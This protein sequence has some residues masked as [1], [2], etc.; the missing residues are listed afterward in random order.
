M[1][2]QPISSADLRTAAIHLSPLTYA[3][4]MPALIPREQLRTQE[5]PPATT[6]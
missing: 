4:D 6:R 3:Q 2:E 1:G 5:R